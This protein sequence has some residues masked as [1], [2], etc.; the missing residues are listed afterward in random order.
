MSFGK[1]VVDQKKGDVKHNFGDDEEFSVVHALQSKKKEEALKAIGGTVM[2]GKRGGIAT[3][4]KQKED[5]ALSKAQTKLGAVDSGEA[6]EDD[7][8]DEEGGSA[9]GA[10]KKK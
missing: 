4:K 3:G 6:A 2:I 10:W 5:E 7:S 8:G 1:R 9:V